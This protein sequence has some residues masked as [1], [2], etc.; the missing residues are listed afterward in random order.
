MIFENILQNL[1]LGIISGI[2]SSIIVSIVFWALTEYRRELDEIKTLIYPLYDFQNLR[3][4]VDAPEDF[5]VKK[6]AKNYLAEI[7]SF[8][9]R[10][11]ECRYHY[12]IKSFIRKVKSKVWDLDTI[13]RLMENEIIQLCDEFKVLTDEFD[14]YERQ[15]IKYFLIR[16]FR[17]RV[18]QLLIFFLLLLILIELLFFIY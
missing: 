9:E 8:F 7:Q 16:V 15:F 4:F 6:M 11:Q 17:N 5:G 18:I 1:I 14:I 13:N 12:E 10:F 2:F 3:E